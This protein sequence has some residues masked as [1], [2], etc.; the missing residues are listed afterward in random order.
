M[1]KYLNFCKKLILKIDKNILLILLI[2]ENP[3]NS[4]SNKTNEI[5]N[6]QRILLISERRGRKTNTYI[7]GWEINE[8]E[9]K[10]HL[11]IL[12]KKFACNGSIKEI[13]SDGVETTV[14]HIQ[15]EHISDLETYL[16]ENNVPKD[17]ISI[18]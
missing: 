15:G 2:M 11:K 4:N 13:D 8:D 17:N 3:F 16:I 18:K 7:S 6:E 12:K 9:M 5:F 14:I 10:H 1:F